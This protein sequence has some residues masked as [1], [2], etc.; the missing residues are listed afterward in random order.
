MHENAEGAKLCMAGIKL[1]YAYKTQK[2]KK[3]LQSSDQ[4][5][6]FQSSVER[7]CRSRVQ[8]LPRTNFIRSSL[9]DEPNGTIW[10]NLVFSAHLRRQQTRTRCQSLSSSPPISCSKQNPLP[11]SRWKTIRSKAVLLAQS[12]S[13]LSFF[14]CLFFCCL[15][16]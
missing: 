1:T 3:I 8:I 9:V 2:R 11:A 4:I 14:L 12:C 15:L 5:A 13:T 16:S 6:P 7:V 10:F